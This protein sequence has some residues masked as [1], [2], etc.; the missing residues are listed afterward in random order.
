MILL[1]LV[2]SLPAMAVEETPPVLDQ[3]GINMAAMRLLLNSFTALG[4]GHVEQVLRGLKL[5]SVTEEARSGEWEKMKGL[6]AAFEQSG[7][8]AAAVWFVRPDGSYYSVEKGLTGQN[9]QNRD[10]F[11]GLMAGPARPSPFRIHQTTG[12]KKA[13]AGAPTRREGKGDRALVGTLCG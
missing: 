3:G 11:P 8:K 13:A 2:L 9:L 10:Y 7:I 12:Q 5:I 1:F 6:L 4:E